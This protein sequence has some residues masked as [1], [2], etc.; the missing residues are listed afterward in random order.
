MSQEPATG[1]VRA[2][3]GVRFLDISMGGALLVVPTAFEVGAIHDF[4]IDLGDDLIWAQCEVRHCRR[5]E[6][7]PGYHVGLQFLGIDP[8][9]ERLLREFVARKK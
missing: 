1:F 3:V 9:D 6:R 7:G 2:Q 8:Q 5:A 4:A